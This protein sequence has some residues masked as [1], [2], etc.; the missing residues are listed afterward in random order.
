MLSHAR[1]G[2][3]RVISFHLRDIGGYRST[4]GYI[5]YRGKEPWGNITGGHVES[6]CGLTHVI[7]SVPIKDR[8]VVGTS[9]KI[10]RM[11]ITQLAR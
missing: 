11:P 10:E 9:D 3:S 5:C 1:T 2:R 8:T 7:P 6:M 4:V